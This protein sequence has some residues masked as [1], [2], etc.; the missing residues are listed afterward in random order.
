MSLVS[1]RFV[2]TLP[3]SDVYE[4]AAQGLVRRAQRSVQ[5]AADAE[6]PQAIQQSHER[7]LRWTRHVY[8]RRSASAHDPCRDGLPEHAGRSRRV[9]AKAT[10]SRRS[11]PLST[12]GWTISQVSDSLLGRS[13]H[14]G[15]RHVQP[16]RRCRA[17]QRN[18]HAARDS[19][20][21]DS[22]HARAWRTRSGTSRC[23]SSMRTRPKTFGRGQAL[24]GTGRA[25]HHHRSARR[26]G[27]HSHREPRYRQH[28]PSAG[29]ADRLGEGTRR[30]AGELHRQGSAARPNHSD[31]RSSPT[32]APPRRL[33]S[34]PAR[35]RT[36]TA[37]SSSARRASERASFRAS[38]TSTAATHSSSRPASGS[39][40]VVARFSGRASS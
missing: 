39:R 12:Q 7:P 22:V 4:K 24:P 30:C 31:G 37:R 9:F 26:S 3:A 13:R 6:R 10:T 1:D 38:T 29:A 15:Q 36:T 25:R 27:R 14:Q 35:F 40:R 20:P 5:R 33:R 21:R 19:Y 34:S 2:D 32:S 8:R 28:V 11:E 23:S 17:D 16:T 18:V